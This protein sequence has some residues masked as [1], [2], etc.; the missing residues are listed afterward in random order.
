MSESTRLNVNYIVNDQYLNTRIIIQTPSILYTTCAQCYTQYSITD[1][2]RVQHNLGYWI[3]PSFDDEAWEP[4]KVAAKD[5]P[6][7]I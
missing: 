7:R 5:N 3:M 2:L 6:D 4:V 1:C